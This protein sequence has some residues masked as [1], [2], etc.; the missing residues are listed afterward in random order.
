MVVLNNG[1]M[2]HVDHVRRDSMDRA[3]SDPSQEMECQDKPPDIPL[4][5]P[6]SVCVQD[7]APALSVR[8]ANVRS[9]V[10]SGQRQAQEEVPGTAVDRALPI[11]TQS[12][13]A[14]CLPFRRFS[15]V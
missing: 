9:E 8:P 6:L 7:P 1:R 12:P 15:R 13:E 3:V 2:R 14:V 5:I 11:V 4:A 10:E